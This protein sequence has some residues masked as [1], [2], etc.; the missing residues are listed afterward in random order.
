MK[1]VVL[2]VAVLVGAALVPAAAQ[3]SP[4]INT[5]DLVKI[6]SQASTPPLGGGP[7]GI[8]GPDGGPALP[9]DFMTFCLEMNEASIV[10]SSYYVQL[11]TVAENGGLGGGNPD[12]LSEQT[13]FLYSRYV[14]GL[15]DDVTSNA[16][17]ENQ[18]SRDA[19]QI[20]I[21]TLEQEA[22]RGVD[23]KYRKNNGNV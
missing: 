7:F 19:L 13:A 8:D 4:L 23:G 9:A 2:L 1:R 14:A 6:V 21:W 12:P 16:Y 3:A 15:L 22:V 11:S 18:T 10:G 5:G 17:G 20:A